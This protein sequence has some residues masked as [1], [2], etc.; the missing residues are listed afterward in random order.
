[1]SL[2]RRIPFNGGYREFIPLAGLK[3]GAVSDDTCQEL[4]LVPVVPGEDERTARKRHDLN[5]QRRALQ[6]QLNHH[7]PPRTSRFEDLRYYF[8]RHAKIID[9]RDYPSC[10]TIFPLKLIASHFCVVHDFVAFQTAKM[11]STGWNLRRETAEQVRAAQEV[12][13]AWSRFRCTEYLEALAAMLDTLGVGRD[14]HYSP[15]YF[16]DSFNGKRGTTTAGHMPISHY[17]SDWRSP[18]N[19]FIFLHRQ[20]TLRR[21]DYDRITTSIAALAGIISG[22]LGI[23]EAKTAKALTFVAMCFAPPEL[24]VGDIRHGGFW[25]RWIFLLAVL[26][27]STTD[28]A[29]CLGCL[30]CVEVQVVGGDSVRCCGHVGRV[31]Y[32]TTERQGVYTS[33]AAERFITL[34]VLVTRSRG[35]AGRWPGY[36]LSHSAKSVTERGSDFVERQALGLIRVM[37]FLRLDP[38][39]HQLKTFT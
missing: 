23:D 16:Y 37:K 22:R 18:I 3:R 39:H 21:E 25:A 13:T 11:R 24:G 30:L 20:F 1:V 28:D 27:N 31:V 4:D 38:T 15:P 5:A 34:C 6:E 17:A 14:D 12:E 19:D 2:T 7:L 29:C 36:G 26:G 32:V 10:V 33:G 8:C 35:Y 9:S